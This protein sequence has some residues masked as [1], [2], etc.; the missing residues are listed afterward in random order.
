MFE[1]CK[2][3]SSVHNFQN[4]ITK[5]LQAIFNLFYGCNSLLYINDISNWNLNNIIF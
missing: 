3:L 5:N 2:S 4:L 1:D